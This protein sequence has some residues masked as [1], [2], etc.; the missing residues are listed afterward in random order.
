M[1]F[2]HHEEIGKNVLFKRLVGF[3]GFAKPNGVDHPHGCVGEGSEREWHST[4]RVRQGL[5]AAQNRARA[6]KPREKPKF[7][8]KT[9]VGRKKPSFDQDDLVS[10]TE[11]NAGPGGNRFQ[12][13]VGKERF[14][15]FR[16]GVEKPGSVG[17]DGELRCVRHVSSGKCAGSLY[18]LAAS[19]TMRTSTERRR[20]AVGG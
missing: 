14:D 2:V 20:N 4:P 17:I 9:G 8:L 16:R 15:R 3:Q 1:T 6:E 18:R 10:R 5:D 19:A 11:G 13:R 7:P 12:R